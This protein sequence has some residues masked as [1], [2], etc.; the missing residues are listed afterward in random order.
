[1]ISKNNKKVPETQGLTCDKNEEGD[2]SRGSEGIWKERDRERDWEGVSKRSKKKKR[3]KDDKRIIEW[4]KKRK[5]RG[6]DK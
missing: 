5:E 4:K 6:K 1:M 3:R 2:R